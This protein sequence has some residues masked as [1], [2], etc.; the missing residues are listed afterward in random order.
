MLDRFS[1]ACDVPDLCGPSCPRL[2]WKDSDEA[3]RVGEPTKE[4]NCVSRSSLGQ[5]LTDGCGVWEWDELYESVEGSKDEE[6]FHNNGL[7]WTLH[8][9]LVPS[10]IKHLTGSV[11][12]VAAG[13]S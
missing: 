1:P 7:G 2:R 10:D 3:T 8:H 9:P 5:H 11:V 12:N 13:A 6:K 4:R